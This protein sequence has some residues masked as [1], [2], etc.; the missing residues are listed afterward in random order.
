MPC[1]SDYMNPNERERELQR[2]AK[3]L[4]YVFRTIETTPPEWLL[5]EANNIYAKDDRSVT[6]LCA[7]LKAMD[8]QERETLLGGRKRTA[9]DLA[10]WWEEHLEADTAREEREAAEAERAR[11]RR[12]GLNKLTAAERDALGIE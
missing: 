5:E 2:S 9:R 1:N 7:T 6:M 10:N 4:V 11:S 12:S 3:L 8:P